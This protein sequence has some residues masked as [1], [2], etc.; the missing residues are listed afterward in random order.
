MTVAK[1][2]STGKS[3]IKP[4]QIFRNAEFISR[5]HRVKGSSG[6][7]ASVHAAG[8]TLRN[9]PG[10][11][12][13]IHQYP[14]GDG[15]RYGTWQTLSNWDCLAGEASL[16]LPDGS[17]L[18]LLSND[19]LNFG[20]FSYSGSV[21]N[22]KTFTV[23][24][25]DE[26]LQLSAAGNS[27]QLQNSVI[28]TPAPVAFELQQQLIPPVAGILGLP[29]G[30]PKI[31]HPALLHARHWNRMVL[32]GVETLDHPES[33]PFGISLSQHHHQLIQAH[34]QL[35][36]TPLQ[37]E[38]QLQTRFYQGTMP[39][40]EAVIA[41]EGVSEEYL[42]ITAHICHPGPC[43]DDN[44]SGCGIAMEL[45][46]T[47]ASLKKQQPNLFRNRGIIMLLVPE[48]LGTLAWLINRPPE[49]PP[50][51]A[52]I[53][54]DMTGTD[55]ELGA[56]VHISQ[57]PFFLKSKLPVMAETFMKSFFMEHPVENY[58]AGAG[59][60]D[61]LITPFSIGSDHHVLCHPDFN[62]PTV[63]FGCWPDPFYHTSADT[64]DHLSLFQMHRI[65]WT[66][67]CVM[68]HWLIHGS[69]PPPP[70]NTHENPKYELST[71][72]N[73]I[74]KRQFTGPLSRS[75]I[76]DLSQGTRSSHLEQLTENRK[77]R[78]LSHLAVAE[79]LIN[80]QRSVHQILHELQKNGRKLDEQLLNETLNQLAEFDLI[81]FLI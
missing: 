52:G 16:L 44:A 45:A 3:L 24:T 63:A 32:T 33:L 14:S 11:T 42:V 53:N 21:P 22:P 77:Y 49:L 47:A 12:V 62:I 20:V 74:P 5:F 40:L 38:V 55:P 58:R 37:C 72:D 43:A 19:D 50:I 7:D 48:I 1:I 34:Q 17:R 51:T 6:L 61:F 69:E 70:I 28:L 79:M 10:I 27:Q 31:H 46:R 36:G 59:K 4:D 64:L 41:G 78:E 68:H 57:P 56:I 81:R 8:E 15:H 75:V 54:L 80:G 35:S 2:A 26:A 71:G 39:V 66:A 13:K 18:N 60:V 67:H 73:R 29:P 23:V 30:L 65:A 25:A 9:I 76:R